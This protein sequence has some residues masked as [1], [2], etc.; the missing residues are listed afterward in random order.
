MKN[1]FRYVFFSV[2]V[3]L[4]FLIFSQS[5]TAWDDAGH[6]LVGYVAW[7]NMTPQA[8]ERAVKLL[9]DAPEDSQIAAFFPTP[10]DYDG[11]TYLPGS[12]SRASKQREFFMIIATWADVVRDRNFTNRYKFHHGTWHYVN[13]F[14]REVNGKVEIIT[15]IKPDKENIVERLF[16]F[17]KVLK[18][19]SAKDAEKSIA[20]AWIL[21]LAG[22][23]H[24][25]LH[26]S[27][28]ITN[29]DP[30]NG[31]QGGNT[32]SLSPKETPRN[33]SV[34]LHSFWDTIIIRS[35]ARKNDASD[36]EYLSPIG[37]NIMKK[38]PLAKVQNQL[39]LGQFDEWQQDSFRIASTKLYPSNLM[40]NTMPSANYQKEAVKISEEQI[41]VAGYRLAQMLNQIFGQTNPA[42]AV[43]DIPCKIIRKVNY[44]VTKIEPAKQPLEIGLLNLCPENKGMMA[45]PM[46]PMMVSGQ[47]KMFEYDVEKIFKTAKEA[48]EYAEK[49]NIKDVSI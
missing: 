37:K 11:A 19:A 36:M 17:D 9:L 21:H 10:P 49:N 4:L 48:R 29:E 25:P 12:R 42:V 34:N 20:L 23:V 30:K 33:Q 43:N 24:Q 6:K 46:Y 47:I 35:I 28:R 18:D 27:G 40:R 38:Y 3:T 16:Y 31:D 41:A 32:F 39:K 44:P 15:D 22:D 2:N 5:V 26:A 8:R 14:W 13:T 1:L 7:E 45:R